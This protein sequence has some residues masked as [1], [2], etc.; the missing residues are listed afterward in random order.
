MSR[1]HLVRPGTTGQRLRD[2]A[3]HLTP[4]VPGAAAVA[5]IG[6]PAL[7]AAVFLPLGPLAIGR[8]LAGNRE[9]GRDHWVRSVD[10]SISIAAYG[11][12]VYGLLQMAVRFEAVGVLVAVGILLL[13][14]LLLNWLLFTMVAAN[15][16]RY[17]ELF[18]PPLVIPLSRW[19]QGLNL[20]RPW[21]KGEF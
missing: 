17:G 8:L 3:I 20:S 7:W 9:P 4:I 11:L 15:R 13:V 6:R 16:A 10:F 18:D 2:A 19:L 21:L 14:L 1:N 12:C 5:V